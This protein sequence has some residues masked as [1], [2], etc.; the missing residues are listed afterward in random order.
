M[1]IKKNQ[2]NKH[3]NDEN[4]ESF[5]MNLNEWACV[6]EGKSKVKDIFLTLK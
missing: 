6:Y 1:A 2:F 3:L 5:M 4:Q